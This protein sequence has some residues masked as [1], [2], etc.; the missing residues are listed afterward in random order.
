MAT[1]IVEQ[2]VQHVADSVTAI[3]GLTAVRPTRLGFTGNAM[4]ENGKV[5]V[6]MGETERDEELSREG[7]PPALAWRQTIEL[8]AFVVES[9]AATTAIDTTIN[10]VRSDIE[11]KLREDPARGGLAI[12]TLIGA[13]EIL[14]AVE[15]VE[16]TGVIVTA[17]VIYRTSEDDP[18][19]SA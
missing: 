6:V 4:P 11:K 12:D 15:G 18:Y 19:T 17:V 9:D 10:Q 3:G 16:F 8:L 1:P 13:P 5:L 14:P 7:H 2:I